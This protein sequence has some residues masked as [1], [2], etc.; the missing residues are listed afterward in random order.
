MTDSAG[1][2]PEFSEPPPRKARRTS[3][4]LALRWLLRGLIGALLLVLVGQLVRNG[5]NQPRA[6]QAKPASEQLDQTDSVAAVT[7][8]S[9]QPRG[10]EQSIV[11]IQ[12]R[13]VTGQQSHGSGFL[14]RD[15]GLVA[16]SLHVSASCTEAIVRLADGTTYEIEGYAAVDRAHDLALLKL[17]DVSASLAGLV[18]GDDADPPR[19]T[20]VWAIGHPKGIEFTISPSEVRRILSTDALP[21]DSQQFL[22]LLTGISS[23]E[24]RWIQHSAPIAP[25]SS[26]GPL[27]D[28][29]GRV[30][31]I[32]TWVDESTHLSYALHVAHLDAL[33]LEVGFAEL[34]P[35]ETHATA[36]ARMNRDLW[37]LS[38]ARLQDLVEQGRGMKWQPQ[39]PK[40][41]YV[42]Q[43]L[44]FAITIARRPDALSVR[45]LLGD[46]LDELAKTAEAAAMQL[47]Q[48]KWN[49]AGQVTI[50]NEYAAEALRRRLSGLFLFATIERVVE[51]DS[52]RGLIATLAGF[53]ESLF[54][55]L[56][57]QLVPP[58]AGA[59]VLVLGVTHQGRVAPWRDEP[60]KPTSF[61]I[62]VPGL[63]IELE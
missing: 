44:A 23:G 13:E 39:S 29:D 40:D 10:W 16:T 63:M 32:N 62:V 34:E 14:V 55:P 4:G 58:E 52:R 27:V 41:Y 24:T 33:M 17:K 15:T 59:Q 3:R 28:K 38:S 53:E 56:E 54:I 48:E 22:H 12:S 45:G 6:R 30:L 20:Q 26:G 43:Q 8:T 47:R 5:W 2:F 49:E 37:L 42:L 25:G 51:E 57:D 19:Q 36:K 61:P 7:R 21:A 60:P 9:P 46:R 11:A 35:L 31:G 18:L 50:L 1:Q